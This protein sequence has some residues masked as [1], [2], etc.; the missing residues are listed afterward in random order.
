MIQQK[1]SNKP[2]QHKLNQI[3]Q[4]KNNNKK[5]NTRQNNIK[6]NILHWWINMIDLIHLHNK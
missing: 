1:K 2:Q 3:N 5:K 4:Q 6:Q